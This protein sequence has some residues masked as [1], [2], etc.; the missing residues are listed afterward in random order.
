M[1]TRP[2]VFVLGAGAS[3]LYGFPSGQQLVEHICESARTKKDSRPS[4]PDDSHYLV[5]RENIQATLID[6]FD[7]H[8]A[9]DFGNALYRSHQLSIDAFLEHRTEFIA[10]G[11]LAIALFILRKE[12]EDELISFENR[13]KGC[14]QYLFSKLN[15]G[16]DDFKQNKVGFITFN[17]DRSLEHFLF[18]SLQNTY[19]KSDQ[20]CAEQLQQIP[21]IHVHGS[22]GKLPWQDAKGIPYGTI[23]RSAS[24]DSSTLNTTLAITASKQIKIIT[25]DQSNSEGFQSAFKLLSEADRIYFLGFGYHSTNLERLPVSSLPKLLALNAFKL[26]SS[27]MIGT[28]KDLQDA[29]VTSVQGRWHIRL[30]DTSSDSLMFLKKYA[31]LD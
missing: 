26:E 4:I 15:T 18:T 17:Y 13:R 22:L 21:V 8:Q 25:E 2:T 7:K 10:I 14:Y 30:P 5:S 20:E 9:E 16:W 28:A 24:S 6:H 29:E 12:M 3:M 27:P 23:E 1:I 19:N 11:K 31:Y